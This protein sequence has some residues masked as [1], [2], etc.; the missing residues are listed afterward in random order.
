M[1]S[2]LGLNSYQINE[3]RR[4]AQSG[5][6]LSAPDAT[7]NSLY[8]YFKAQPKVQMPSTNGL[9]P[10]QISEIQ[11][12]AAS[13]QRLSAP[14][15]SKQN[16]YNY[17]A[18]QRLTHK[19]MN[20]SDRQ[21]YFNYSKNIQYG[22][23]N[24]A[25]YQKYQN[26][27]D[28][29]GLKK[30]TFGETALRNL[31]QQALSG[32][33]QAQAFLKAAGVNAVT[34]DKLWKNITNQQLD[35]SNALRQQYMADNPLSDY[36]KSYDMI[37]YKKYN[38][39]IMKNEAMTPQQ[40]EWY[41]KMVGKWGLDDM[42]DPFNQKGYQLEKDRDAA[43]AAED[44]ALNQGLAASDAS[45]FQQFQQLQ[46]Q[47]AERGMTDSGIFGDAMTR[48]QMANNQV[49]QG[50]FSE[51]ATKKSDIRSQFNQ[52]ISQNKLDKQTY[53]NERQAQ[54]AEMQTNAL[55]AQATLQKAQTE[56]DQYLTSSTGYV[57]VNGQ[58]LQYKGKPVT[59][60]EYAKVM[61][62]MR[63]N[64]ATEGLTGQKNAWDYALGQAGIQNDAQRNLWEYLLGQEKNSITAQ[65]NL[66]DFQQGMDANAAK[67]E[68]IAAQLQQ[69][70][71]KNQLEYAKLDYNYAKLDAT[72]AYNQ[73]KIKIAAA[74]AQTSADKN[75]L[76]A[77]G[78]QSDTLAKQIIAAQ[79]AGKKPSKDIV[80]KYNNIN[81]QISSLVGG[82]SFSGGGS[83][84]DFPALGQ[85]GW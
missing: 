17:Y 32:D 8:S 55:N 64:M 9:T 23:A 50:Q 7:K 25:D 45:N 18:G 43:L 34:G 14:T 22:K 56:Q 57:Y 44:V 21:W 60:L 77:L 3:I 27:V 84:S 79:K 49:M 69:S 54:L 1:P 19:D 68:Q 66:W 81:D 61:E 82:S 67:R 76:T 78:K 13:G 62:E 31:S 29:Y 28:T 74:N 2:T 16:L 73:E 40:I 10:Y 20:E 39:M 4:K 47:M 48:Q 59:S 37:H 36:A 33:S 53:D 63:H 41:N 80:D 15:S 71:A 51:S 30:Y 72:N 35:G 58:M 52:A 83:G 46:Q 70:I 38:D 65:N 26:L 11:R 24:Q 75:Q 5:Q 42:N 6:A 85:G 12:K